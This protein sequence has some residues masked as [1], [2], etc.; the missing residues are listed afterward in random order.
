M[1]FTTK[2][3][4]WQA[5]LQTIWLSNP[6]SPSALL[7]TWPTLAHNLITASFHHVL[8]SVNIIPLKLE[9]KKMTFICSLCRSSFEHNNILA[10]THSD[11]VGLET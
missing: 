11:R 3:G 8:I 1:I 7:S 6:R 10:S 2:Q 4:N 5:L 9:T